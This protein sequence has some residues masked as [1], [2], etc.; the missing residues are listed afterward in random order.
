MINATPF[1]VNT[2][3]LGDIEIGGGNIKLQIPFI[4]KSL[5]FNSNDLTSLK[6][7]LTSN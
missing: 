6:D 7:I 3:I 4:G 1:T 2:G 5:V